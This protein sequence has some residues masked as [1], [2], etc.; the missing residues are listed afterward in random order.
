MYKFFTF[1]FLLISSFCFSQNKSKRETLQALVGTHQLYDIS[2]L[3]GANSMVDYNKVNGKWKGFFSMI[4][5]GMRNGES[6]KIQPEA[7]VRLNTMELVVKPDLSIDFN[8]NKRTLFSIPYLENGMV[9]EMNNKYDENSPHDLFLFKSDLTFK[10]GNLYLFANDNIDLAKLEPLKFEY[11]ESDVRTV[12]LYYSV[13]EKTFNLI[14]CDN[15]YSSG[16][17]TYSFKKRV[18]KK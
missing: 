2:G 12:Y 18:I 15:E 6:I 9:L 17:T 10:N 14:H 13:K 8:C 1:I 7:L 11:L 16:I 4:M 3:M 5:S